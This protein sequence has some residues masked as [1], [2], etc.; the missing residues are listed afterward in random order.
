MG[1]D[2]NGKEL[3]K[4]LIQDKNG[5]YVARFSDR[6]GKRQSKRFNK[7]Q[8]ARQWLADSQYIDEHSDMSMPRDMTVDA[9]FE[10]WHD[11][12]QKMLKPGTADYYKLRYDVSIKPIIGNMKLADVKA[13][14][15]Q[16]VVNRM[17]DDNKS[18]STI[19]RTCTVMRGIFNYAVE[20]DI[21][22]KSPC[23]VKI[24][25]NIGKKKKV[26]EVLTKEAQQ[27]FL[28][29]IKGHR[30]EYQF[31]FILQTGLR[32]GEL[33]GLKWEDVNFEKRT[34][35]INRT[36]Q[37]VVGKGIWRTGEPKSHAGKRTIP[38]TNEAIKILKCQKEKNSALKVIPL[39]W[40]DYVFLNNN[41]MPVKT[42]TYDD[43]LVTICR[44]I[45][46]KKI[47]VHVLR[48][49]FAT[50]IVESGA[51]KIKTLSTIMGHSTI[52]LT[53]DLYVHTTDD[54]MFNEIELV[55]NALNAI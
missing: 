22:M 44:K 55:A 26:R 8:E 11:T 29:Y 49:T 19:A 13:N 48:H 20:C 42:D 34:I 14:H 10:F 50:R 7:L 15:C 40:R 52:G 43:A 6:F 3:G 35:T 4:G 47:S 5:K 16:M 37:Y 17:V 38:L 2:L 31:K 27:K 53:M 30:Y 1:K 25:S 24:T 46:I 33:T 39:E 21:I 51:M 12:V 32:I 28:Q 36:M 45:D 23:I 54:E 41:G 18:N 9:F